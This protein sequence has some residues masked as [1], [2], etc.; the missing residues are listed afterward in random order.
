M[1]RAMHD[2]VENILVEVQNCIKLLGEWLLMRSCQNNVSYG[3]SQDIVEIRFGWSF[4]VSLLCFRVCLLNSQASLCL[5]GIES[6]L[7]GNC[8]V[9]N[10][11]RNWEMSL[12][13]LCYLTGPDAKAKV[14]SG[15][16]FVWYSKKTYF[17]L[18]NFIF[19]WARSI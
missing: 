5:E 15:A 2:Q 6:A 9:K 11:F 12:K 1:T 17:F 14:I 10:N 7:E 19:L 3:T 8:R 13:K 16:M 4:S 18:F